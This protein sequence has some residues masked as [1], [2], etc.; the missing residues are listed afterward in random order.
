MA[1]IMPMVATPGGCSINEDGQWQLLEVMDADYI[2]TAYSKGLTENSPSPPCIKECPGTCY[3]LQWFDDRRAFGWTVITENIFSIPGYGKL[4]VESIYTRDFVTVQGA[5]LVS[6][7]LVVVVN[8]FVDILYTVIDP[9]IKSGKEA[10][11]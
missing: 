2:R 3:H 11:A 1:M 7:L 9:R 8:L 6:A 10:G 4:I 5:I